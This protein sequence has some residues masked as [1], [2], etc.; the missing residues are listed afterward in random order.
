M[1]STI[2]GLAAEVNTRSNWATS[3]LSVIER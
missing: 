1:R 2:G 3:R